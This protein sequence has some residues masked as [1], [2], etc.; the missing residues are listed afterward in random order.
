MAVS[1]TLAQGAG[2]YARVQTT[3]GLIIGSII[4][5]IL[6][7]ISF[8]IF[9]SKKIF[10]EEVRATI[11]T[12]NCAQN[13]DA[14]NKSLTYSCN[15]DVKYTVGTETFTENITKNAKT[16]FQVG[17]PIAIYY[18]KGNPSNASADKD[19]NKVA[20]ILLFVALAIVG[21]TYMSYYFTQ[22]YSGFATVSGGVS[23]VSSIAQVFKR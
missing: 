22:K 18:E 5:V 19:T 12:V 13:H 9:S 4:A 14:Q 10:T 16:K 20:Y 21:L 17:E 7:I 2:E 8:Y 1:E 15:M 6:L 11:Q 3:I 23:A